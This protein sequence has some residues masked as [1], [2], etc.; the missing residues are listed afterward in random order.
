MSAVQLQVV[1]C[2][3]GRDRFSFLHIG[4]RSEIRKN[5]AGVVGIRPIR[6]ET[7][8]ERDAAITMHNVFRGEG[9]KRL[10][11]KIVDAAIDIGRRQ[12]RRRRARAR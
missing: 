4:L 12:R 5:F 8:A 6:Y 1:T 9:F 7:E 11:D 10:T 3:D 2:R